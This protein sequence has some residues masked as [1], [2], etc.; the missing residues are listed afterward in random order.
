MGRLLLGAA[1][2]FAFAALQTPARADVTAV[3]GVSMPAAVPL[4]GGAV[5]VRWTVQRTGPRTAGQP[6]TV[7]S[8]GAE[9]WAGGQRVASF[10]GTL[11]RISAPA[12]GAPETLVFS[13]TLTV[14]ASAMRAVARAN[15][16][17]QIRRT[18]TDEGTFPGIGPVGSAASGQAVFSAA[19]NAQGAL[20]LRRIE[21]AFE[22]GSRTGVFRTGAALRAVA[23]ISYTANGILEAE[24]RVARADGGGNFER[25]LGIVRQPLASAGQGRTRLVSPELPDDM[26]GLYEVRLVVRQPQ[27]NFDLPRLRYYISAGDAARETGTLSLIGPDEKAPVTA[28][29]VFAWQPVSGAQA[30]QIEIF[31][32]K[33]KPGGTG[34]RTAD[35]APAF[36]LD[37]FDMETPLVAGKVVPASSSRARLNE[38]SL[39][40]LESGE[41][42]RWR[43]RAID[44]RGQ[45]I[46]QSRLRFLSMP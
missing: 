43:V 5:Q 27:L 28:A 24:W 38:A 45:V 13:E 8:A 23:D 40:Y 29:T 16:P 26:T 20:S 32:D 14:P 6:T 33:R 41:T 25:S 31:A 35:T 7:R 9:L 18:F 37:V 30:Y 19:G 42:Y 3:S 11:Q 1:M 22:D 2:A 39:Q 46:A 44:A 10:P 21:L 36:L 34:P 12:F 4:T 17:A 15:G